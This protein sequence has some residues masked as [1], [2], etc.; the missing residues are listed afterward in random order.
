[1][2][3]SFDALLWERYLVLCRPWPFCGPQKKKLQTFLSD[4]GLCGKV[5]K[6]AR[7][8]GRGGATGEPVKPAAGGST[9][10]VRRVD[11]QRVG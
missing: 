10:M 7:E 3:A 2:C 4:D 11:G 8:K 1:M 5:L 9:T 6:L